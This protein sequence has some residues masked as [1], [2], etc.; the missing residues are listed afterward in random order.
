ML[1]VSLLLVSLLVRGSV[2]QPAVFP[3]PSLAGNTWRSCVHL[4]AP[5]PTDNEILCVGFVPKSGPRS[6]CALARYAWNGTTFA[7]VPDSL[8][9]PEPQGFDAAED[10]CRYD[11][12]GILQR[13]PLLVA[14][15]GAYSPFGTNNAKA[16]LEVW[17]S[18]F[19]ASPRIPATLV[20]PLASRPD[21][22]RQFASQMIIDP[23][24]RGIVVSGHEQGPVPVRS[25]SARFF[26]NGTSLVPDPVMP[27]FLAPPISRAAGLVF[28]SARDVYAVLLLRFSSREEFY[29]VLERDASSGN[30]LVVG[31]PSQPTTGLIRRHFFEFDP[32][33]HNIVLG[34]WECIHPNSINQTCSILEPNN[35]RPVLCRLNATTYEPKFCVR[36]EIGQDGPLTPTRTPDGRLYAII[37]TQTFVP[38]KA[39]FV[40]LDVSGSVILN[41]TGFTPSPESQAFVSDG[42]QGTGLIS[43]QGDPF[44]NYGA[45]IWPSSVIRGLMESDACSIGGAGQTFDAANCFCVKTDGPGRRRCIVAGDGVL[46]SAV[47]LTDLGARF[48]RTIM[49]F[50]GGLSIESGA[51]I[52]TSTDSRIISLRPL[53]LKNDS[54][55]LSVRLAAPGTTYPVQTSASSRSS[56]R[57]C[58]GL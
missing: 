43:N 52:T 7:Q 13:S 15:F 41:Q 12:V 11:A 48:D 18:S 19:A 30:S 1:L 24:G 20:T 6:F 29:N 28:D 9:F 14:V 38:L 44:F 54:S 49:T 45:I 50:E 55:V 32:I 35:F 8:E 23:R 31:V 42:T 26:L 57:R 22:V 21:N 10:V 34:F 25:F 51:Q 16:F 27:Y 33:F 17:N 5:P 58:A 4:P 53:T 46:S 36:F 39:S 3:D 37:L 56:R 47:D 40:G 2:S